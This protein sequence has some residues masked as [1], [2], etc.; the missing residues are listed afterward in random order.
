MS[1]SENKN[2]CAATTSDNQQIW[3][4]AASLRECVYC[5][6]ILS[7][8][9]LTHCTTCKEKHQTKA[10]DAADMLVV[11]SNHNNVMPCPRMACS[12]SDTPTE[13]VPKSSARVPRPVQTF[14]F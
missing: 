7:S 3:N 12:F 5:Q 10:D 4:L 1:V 14:V 6:E 9:E 2:Q 11:C 13:R 8:K